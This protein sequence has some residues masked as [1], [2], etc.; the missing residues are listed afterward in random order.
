MRG[1]PFGE[2]ADF[3]S[4][5]LDGTADVFDDCLSVSKDNLVFDC[6][7]DGDGS[8]SP[9]T[10]NHATLADEESRCVATLFLASQ[11]EL[12]VNGVTYG[13]D[14]PI[15]PTVQKKIDENT[16]FVNKNTRIVFCF[17]CVVSNED[18]EM[19]GDYYC[20][21]DIFMHGEDYVKTHLVVFLDDAI[22]QAVMEDD[23]V[24]GEL[25]VETYR[26]DGIEYL[27]KKGKW[28]SDGSAP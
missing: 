18:G 8:F 10:K 13:E 11:A 15:P 16:E 3:P 2:V 23:I 4:E 21:E 24:S 9:T 12:C 17:E 7:I 22:E 20:D 6:F 26:F 25:P 5:Y 14:D 1:T 28:V 19:I 27:A